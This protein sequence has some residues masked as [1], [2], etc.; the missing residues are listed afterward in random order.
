MLIVDD[1]TLICRFLEE[2]VRALGA[3]P[4]AARTATEAIGLIDT[5]EFD[6]ALI[7]KN[8]PDKSGIEV[9]R[10]LKS[11]RPRTEALMIT[12]YANVDSALEA[13]R[14]GAFDYL[15]KPFDGDTLTH[16]LKLALERRSMLAENT[17]MEALLV[18][19]D[20]MSSVGT[21]AAGIGHEINNPLA[22]LLSN[23][24][25]VERELPT[26]EAGLT[27]DASLRRKLAELQVAIEES[28]EG[29]QRVAAIVRD[30]RTFA[31]IDDA[32][33]TPIDARRICESAAKMA[34]PQ[35]RHR[36]QLI[37]TLAEVPPVKGNEGRLAQV[38]LNLLVNASQS[39]AEGDPE[40]PQGHLSCR[41]D[42]KNRVVI[43]VRDTGGGIAPRAGANLR[44]VL[45]HQ[46]RR[47]RHRPGSV[48][49]PR[50]RHRNGR[51]DRGREPGG[52]GVG[53]QGAAPAQRR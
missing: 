52:G 34:I 5:R 47:H 11:K 33:P 12:G 8:L 3:N 45:H 26:L 6:C 44:S 10:H 31:R 40:K 32:E 30:L 20:R 21:L 4:T 37:Q 39:L 7:D 16:R 50:N 9:L 48:D 38:V 14:L 25:Y 43:E 22:F 17:R 41:R 2:V 36:A 46:R 42:L 29:A 53:V 27:A 28:R 1:E 51:R 13:L 23:L 15:L 19:A 18:H 24:E 35:I 49:L